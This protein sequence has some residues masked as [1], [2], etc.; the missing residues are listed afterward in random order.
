MYKKISLCLIAATSFSLTAQNVNKKYLK[1]Q[2]HNITLVDSVH[3][4]LKEKNYNRWSLNLNAGFNN[5][6]GPFTT[7]YYS[8]NTNYITDPVFNRIDFNVR[9]MFNTKFGIRLDLGF[10]NF[11]N[12]GKSMPF[13]NSMYT[14]T[15][16]GVFNVHRALNWEE[17]TNT[18]GLQLHFGPGISFLESDVPQKPNSTYN[19]GF[20]HFDNIYTVGS[21]ATVLIKFSERLAFNLDYSM[22][23]NFSHHLNLDG[24]T[25]VDLSANRTGLNHT[26]TAGI[27]LYLGKK[28]KHADWY[29]EP[30]RD[31]SKELLARMES[32]ES[33]LSDSNKDGF[34]DKWENYLK[35]NTSK[36]SAVVNNSIEGDQYYTTTEA[37]NMINSQYVN[38]FFDFDQSKITTGTIS[39]IFFLIKYLNMNP[40]LNVEVIGYAD[41]FGNPAYN[42]K[43]S[44]TRAKNVA[45]MIVRAGIDASRLKI[46]IKGED[47]SVPKESELARQLVRR[48][49]FRVY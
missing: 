24:K 36:N 12:V 15:I 28:D 40:T 29:W 11:S 35:Q 10:D 30:K 42:M 31:N 43:L 27:T 34:P 19:P 44:E 25:K 39:S 3:P 26:V 16:Q 1:S 4:R 49:A 37:R 6:T 14:G 13:N 5:P 18:F 17:F 48:V 9:K 46:V 47:N 45:E 21:G 41:E 38:V 8:A 33:Q 20:F 2:E 23:K 32:L 22:M 7:G